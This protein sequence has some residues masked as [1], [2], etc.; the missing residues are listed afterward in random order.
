MLAITFK[1]KIKPVYFADET[2][3][4]EGFPLPKSLARYA[5]RAAFRQSKRFGI[6]ANSDLFE[7]ILSRE[8][9]RLGVP[10]YI[11]LGSLPDCVTIEPGF[12]ATVTIVIP[13]QI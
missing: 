10:N 4:Y 11:K 8:I 6:Y 7:S 5:D 9:K 2:L 3:A 13:G 12:M 1:T